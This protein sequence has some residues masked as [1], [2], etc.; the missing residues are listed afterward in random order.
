MLRPE[1]VKGTGVEIESG[2]REIVDVMFDRLINHMIQPLFVLRLARWCVATGT[3]ADIDAVRDFLTLRIM[4][5]LAASLDRIVDHYLDDTPLQGE[6]WS[7][8]NI[9]RARREIG[10]LAR[11]LAAPQYVG[12]YD[13]DVDTDDR[14]MRRENFNRPYAPVV[15]LV[16][17]VGEE[18]IDLQQHTRYVLHYDVEWNPAKMEQREGRVDREG[19]RTSDDGA[20][21]V[22]FFLLKDTYEE[23]IFH[24][25]MQRDAWFQIMIGSKRDEL[26]KDMRVE[27][28]ES[29]GATEIVVTDDR[30]QLTSEERAAVMLDL[31]P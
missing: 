30:S 9:E 3:P 28:A 27:G 8:E 25:V 23:R 5:R 14:E 18:G 26:A 20:V 11:I 15:L 7:E 19:R 24:T 21:R 6:A 1:H 31:R 16:S 22:N 4:E 29:D 17:A 13:G 10:R 2:E 12:R